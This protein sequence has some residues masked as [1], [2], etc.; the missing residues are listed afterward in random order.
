MSY[1][2]PDGPTVTIASGQTDSPPMIMDETISDSD[3]FGILTPAA[4][5]GAVSIQVSYNFDKGYRHG[6]NPKTAAQAAADATWV[7]APAG[8]AL[9][10]VGVQAIIETRLLIAAAWRIHS[11][12]AEGADRV[13]RCYR[14]TLDTH[15]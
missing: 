9:G 2:M 5:T 7:A 4:L 10:A 14:R 12:L 15:H 11:T 3:W 1:S 8:T 6:T 13:F